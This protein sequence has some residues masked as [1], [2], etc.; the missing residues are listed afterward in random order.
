MCRKLVTRPDSFSPTMA[1]SCDS[2][3]EDFRSDKQESLMKQACSRHKNGWCGRVVV[4][5]KPGWC[6]GVD[7]VT[8]VVCTAGWLQSARLVG[9]A[10]LLQLARL[11]GTADC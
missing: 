7:A 1:P 2:A 3:A 6:S 8:G 10:R 11:L 9:T 4:G 5:S